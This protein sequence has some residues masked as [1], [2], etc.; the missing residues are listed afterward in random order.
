MSRRTTLPDHSQ[1]GARSSTDVRT[2]LLELTREFV[3]DA[4][5]LAGVERIAVLGSILTRNPRPKDIDVLVSISDGVDLTT[6]ARLGRRL[7][8]MAQAK[9]NS[10]ADVFL[11]DQGGHY[12]GRVCHYRDCHPRVLCR[13]KHCGAIPHV[14]DDF[15]LVHL[16]ADLIAAPPLELHPAIV[17]RGTVPAD[18]EAL[19]LAPIRADVAA[20]RGVPDGA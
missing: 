8:G 18:V 16:G 10:G 11:A 6:L 19:L 3:S 17:A 7:K 2:T 1:Y 12:I 13:A 20:R 4:R 15:D 9:L 5:A 14:A